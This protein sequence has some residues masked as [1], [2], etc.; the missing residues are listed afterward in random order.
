MRPASRRSL[1]NKPNDMALFCAYSAR[2][3]PAPLGKTSRRRYDSCTVEQQAASIYP[4]EVRMSKINGDKAR[5]NLKDRKAANRRVR[6]RAMR[7]AGSAKAA[8]S[9]RK[10]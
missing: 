8:V 6:D 3:S 4:E 9:R 2:T 10:G 7:D 5:Q 1:N